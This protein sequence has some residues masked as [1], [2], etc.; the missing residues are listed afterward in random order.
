MPKYKTP[1]NW[2]HPEQQALIGQVVN[3]QICV[4]HDYGKSGFAVVENTPTRISLFVHFR[5][6][7]TT[8][9]ETLQNR[10]SN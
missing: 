4:W 7:V 3:A 2:Q 6:I 9:E 8:G 10:F 5:E 1:N